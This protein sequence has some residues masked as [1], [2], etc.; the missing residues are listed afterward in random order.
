V[1]VDDELALAT[2]AD[3]RRRTRF[4][5]EVESLRGVAIA[6]VF[7]HHIDG[8]LTPGLLHGGFDVSLPWAFIAGGQSGVTLFFVL[9]AF[10][11]SLP[12]LDRPAGDSSL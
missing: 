3:V 8:R 11:L 5:P 10:C 2:P 1:S 7:L 6:L 9:S 4:L 12:F